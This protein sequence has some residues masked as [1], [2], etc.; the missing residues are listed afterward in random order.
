MHEAREHLDD[1]L[2]LVRRDPERLHR[3]DGEI[4]L[5]GV[6]HALDRVSSGLVNVANLL[7][8]GGE[9]ERCPELRVGV[10]DENLIQRVEVPLAGALQHKA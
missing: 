6:I 9:V 8:A 3:L 10:G 4:P 2:D 5:R 7:Q 1:L